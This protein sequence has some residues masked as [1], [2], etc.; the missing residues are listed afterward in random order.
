MNINTL[1]IIYFRPTSGVRLQQRN[2]TSKLE[3]CGLD[4]HIKIIN[5]YF[6]NAISLGV[7][8]AHAAKWNAIIVLY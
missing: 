5:Y 1:E 6:A 4:G 3:A 7:F 2:C 8:I